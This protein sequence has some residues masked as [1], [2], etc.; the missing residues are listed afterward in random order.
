M[1]R[2]DC[3]VDFHYR[4]GIGREASQKV[5][6][7]LRRFSK[8]IEFGGHLGDVYCNHSVIW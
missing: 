5:P 3:G 6:T 7:R 4:P 8:G 1:L 2:V